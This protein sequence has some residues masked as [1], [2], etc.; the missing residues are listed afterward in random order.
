MPVVEVTSQPPY[1][2]NITL[3]QPETKNLL[4]VSVNVL[5]GGEVH[6][7]VHSL[8]GEATSMPSS[9][10]ISTVLSR[11]LSIPMMMKYTIK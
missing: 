3:L 9:S 4:C 6:A 10:F 8:P 1:G 11:C 7:Q 5:L 2:L